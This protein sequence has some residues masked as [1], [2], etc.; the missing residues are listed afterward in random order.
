M[1]ERILV[2]GGEG[3][4]QVEILSPNGNGDHQVCPILQELQGATGGIVANKEPLFC[5]GQTCYTMDKH[6]LLE[7]ITSLTTPLY[8]SQSIV[9]GDTLVLAGGAKSI[10]NE[11]QVHSYTISLFDLD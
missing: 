7:P 11:R 6:G 5:Q 1:T 10:D 8:Y 3:S 2:I 9:S 4:F